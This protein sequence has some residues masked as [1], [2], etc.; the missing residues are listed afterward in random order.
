MWKY[1]R[2]LDTE[3]AATYSPD[4]QFGTG[5]NAPKVRVAAPKD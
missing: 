5:A 3:N 2:A 4:G 1:A